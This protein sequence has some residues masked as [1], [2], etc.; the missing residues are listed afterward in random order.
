MGAG[1]RRHDRSLRRPR[2]GPCAS[3]G[4]ARVALECHLRSGS[5]LVCESRPDGV[6][7]VAAAQ[8]GSVAVGAG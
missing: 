5:N 7:M 8:V 2:V 3:L 4:W 6:A 1:C